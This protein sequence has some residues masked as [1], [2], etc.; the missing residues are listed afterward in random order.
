MA[1]ERRGPKIEPQVLF[2]PVMDANFDTASYKQFADG[3]WLTWAA[4]QW[5]WDAYLPDPARRGEI[6]AT[7]LNASI[8]QL[9]DLPEALVIVGENDVLRDEGEAYAGKLSDAGIHCESRRWPQSANNEWSTPQPDGQ[10]PAPQP[11]TLCDAL[12][13]THRPASG[14][15]P[16]VP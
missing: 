9:R 10:S 4:M 1:K 15:L 7:P 16:S 12:P 11:I 3:L 5:Y 13:A 2:Y 14:C 8:D 6:T